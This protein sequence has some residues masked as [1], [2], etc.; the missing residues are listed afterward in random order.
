MAAGLA[1][2]LLAIWAVTVAI[3]LLAIGTRPERSGALLAVFPLAVG[4]AA[5]LASV[6]RAEGSLVGPT[7]LPNVWHVYGEAPRFAGALRDQGASL[8]LPPLPAA[9]FR[10]GACFGMPLTPAQ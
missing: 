6:S 4:E 7:W 3:T 8:V 5:I 2:A 10:N 1:L 9:I